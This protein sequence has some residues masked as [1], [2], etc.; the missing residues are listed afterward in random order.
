MQNIAEKGNEFVP[1]SL[2]KVELFFGREILQELVISINVER[3]FAKNEQL[4]LFLQK[5]YNN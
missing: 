5:L 1:R 3:F 2:A 4:L